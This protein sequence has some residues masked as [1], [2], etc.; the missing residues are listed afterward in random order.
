MTGS[1]VSLLMT[2]KGLPLA[3]NKDLQEDKEPVFDALDTLRDCLVV[4]ARTMRAATFH[5][6]RMASGLRAGFVMATDIADALV[7]AGVPFRDA[8]HRVGAL[9]NHCASKGTELESL[10]AQEWQELTPELTI[11][12]VRKAL[13]PIVSLSRR[14]QPGGPAPVRVSEAQTAHGDTVARLRARANSSRSNTELMQ[15]LREGSK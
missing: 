2:L 6:K 13:D 5:P 10:T 7:L 9:V 8:H 15:W 1:L 14:S 12:Q 11:E 3:Y 4:L